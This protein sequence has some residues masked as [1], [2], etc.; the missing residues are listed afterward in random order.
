MRVPDTKLEPGQARIGHHRAVAVPKWI[1]P[2]RTPRTDYI[3]PDLCV[4]TT[5]ATQVDYPLILA[6]PLGICS[7]N[8]LPL[9]IAQRRYASAG[10][11]YNR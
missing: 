7:E 9:T 11:V 2:P 5:R 8:R 10:R 6:N 4:L 3:L 1:E